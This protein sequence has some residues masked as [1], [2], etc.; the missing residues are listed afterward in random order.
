M[1]VSAGD[2]GGPASPGQRGPRTVGL[3][4]GAV[5]RLRE[6]LRDPRARAE[7]HACVIEGPRALDAAL[8][9]GT[10]VEAVYLGPRAASAFPRLVAR[11]RDGG[12][13][14][15][16]LKEGVLEKVGT[17][18]TPQPVLAIA[19]IRRADRTALAHDGL[20]VVAAGVADPGNL[21]TI[22][23]SAEASGAAAILL[24]PGSVDAYN[25][26]VVRASVGA[27][28]GIPLVD[29]ESEGWSAVEALDALG[30]LGRQRLGAVAGGG[31]THTEVD[32]TRPTAVV[33]GNEAHGIDGA[34]AARLDGQVSI[35]MAGPAESLN[36][37]MAATVLCFE[38]ARQRA[39]ATA[40]PSGEVDPAY[41]PV[42]HAETGAAEGE[43]A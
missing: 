6:L 25:P 21:G 24:G 8:D 43:R 7:A 40:A 35:P 38:S 3:R 4:H 22:V 5:K 18:R 15:I 32:F 19:T 17:T 23:R 1:A 9:R 26:K 37:A 12:V 30:E 20:V 34:L 33:L 29:A 42:R 14:A 39:G 31:R 36:V 41:D 13:E 2:G 27:V 28:F 10:P 16:E 11:L